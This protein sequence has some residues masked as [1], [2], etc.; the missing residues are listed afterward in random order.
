[1]AHNHDHDD[2]SSGAVPHDNCGLFGC[3]EVEGTGR[4]QDTVSDRL[5]TRKQLDRLAQMEEVS[6]EKVDAF[7]TAKG[8]E[9]RGLLKSG[10]M[11]G[12]LA[13]VGPLFSGVAKAEPQK[14][15]DTRGA[16]RE[17]W[18]EGRTHVVES[19]SESVH[20]GVF[21]STLPNLV[22]ID[23]GDHI[24]YPNT[25]S[26]FLNELQPGLPIETIAQLRLDNPGKGPHSIIGPVGVRDAEPGDVLE[27]R[28]ERLLPMD[29]G[30]NFNNPGALNTGALPDVFPEGQVKY[31]DLDVDDM[32]TKFNDFITLDLAPFQGTLG[33]APPTGFFGSTNGIVTSVPPGPHGGN[34]DLRELN[35]GS[36]LF[37]PV[38]QPGAK[39]FTGDSHALQGDGEIN[40]CALETRMQEMR[41]RVILHKQLNWTFP[42]V[43]TETHWIA[44]GMDRS[45]D[46]AFRNAALNAIDFLEKRCGLSRLDAY[47][48]CSIAVSF[49]ITQVVDINRGVHAM[50]P[51]SIF[52][53]RA[54]REISVL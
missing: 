16:F 13:L 31:F 26:H 35:E 22:E 36:R 37:L 54:R 11:L 29:W 53:P 5:L 47:S 49:R 34:I 3:G 7:L 8:R 2:E 43:E 6:S 15:R 42:F 19:N 4:I 17:G 24:V 28:Y 41:I 18:N 38:W 46:V 50:I 52:D 39:I 32:R 51:K 44:L 21:N 30:V 27:I 48:L 33:V 12:A 1:M 10:G 14:R 40:L 9:R 23:S 25:W 45:L 20:L